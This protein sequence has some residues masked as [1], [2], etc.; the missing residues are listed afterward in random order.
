MPY[1]LAIPAL[2]NTPIGGPVRSLARLTARAWPSLFGYQFV[3]EA[4]RP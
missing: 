1:E 2:G 3:F 4:R